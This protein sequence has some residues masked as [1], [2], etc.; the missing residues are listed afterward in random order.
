MMF[1]GMR[2]FK[3][4]AL[5]AFLSILLGLVIAEGF[6][7]YVRLVMGQSECVGE[8]WAERAICGDS[9]YTVVAVCIGIAVVVVV[10]GGY[11]VRR[12]RRF[13]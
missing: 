1:Q 7:L 4:P 5:Y 8:T 10:G 2:D 9:G 11:L 6:V 3:K 12:L 13:H